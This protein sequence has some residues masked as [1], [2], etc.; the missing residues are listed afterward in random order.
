MLELINK[1]L[2]KYYFILKSRKYTRLL[3]SINAWRAKSIDL[4]GSAII[5]LRFTKRSSGWAKFD[6]GGGISEERE[7]GGDNRALSKGSC[8]GM[9][10]LD[11][12]VHVTNTSGLGILWT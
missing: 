3:S 6:E 7:C 5:T 12:H 1:G 2:M 8:R 9:S 11:L 10:G 4:K